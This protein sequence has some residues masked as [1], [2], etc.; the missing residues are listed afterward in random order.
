MVAGASSDKDEGRH[1]KVVGPT[2]IE[3]LANGLAPVEIEKRYGA[4][5]G[6]KHRRVDD[7]IVGA[8]ALQAHHMPGVFISMLFLVF[9]N[10]RVSLLA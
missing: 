7:H 8:R 9:L 3:R 6:H 5:V 2:W 4:V 10:G 1:G